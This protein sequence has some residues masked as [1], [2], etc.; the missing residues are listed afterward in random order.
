MRIDPDEKSQ[1]KW[2]IRVCAVYHNKH[3]L[4]KA[5]IKIT[6]VKANPTLP[7]FTGESPKFLQVI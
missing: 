5:K 3:T 6:C 2:F 7:K 1:M 4:Y